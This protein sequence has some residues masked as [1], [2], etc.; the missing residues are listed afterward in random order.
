MEKHIEY[1][2]DTLPETEEVI[3][4]YRSS[5]IRRPI[6]DPGRI[7]RMYQHSNLVVSAWDDKVLVGV[8]RSVTD[9]AYCCYLSDLAVRADYQKMGI[10]KKLI[11][12]TRKRIGEECMLLLLSATGAM[13]YYPRLGFEKVANGFVIHRSR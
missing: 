9:F 3:K 7:H 4:L 2:S 1:R 10:G 5:G 12:L 8:A 13:E 6:E 11:E